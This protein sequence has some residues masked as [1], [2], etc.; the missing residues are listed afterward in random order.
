MSQEIDTL[1]EAVRDA[2]TSS[3][4]SRGVE[5]A[6]TGS[7]HG[8]RDDGAEVV[9][10][11]ATPGGLVSP[12]VQLFPEDEDWDCDCRARAA[13]CEHTAAAVISLRQARR[14]GKALPER[15]RSAGN[16]G[17]RLS[18][19]GDG[20]AI[21]RMIVTERGETRL[22]T[23]LAALASG[24][25]AGPDFVATQGDLAVEHTLGS[26]RRGR[27]P[28]GVLP[29]LV[30]QLGE[31]GDIRLDG[32]PVAASADALRFV[33]VVED[34]DTGF[35][36]RV[37]REELVD[38]TFE[39]CIA[40][41]NKQLRPLGSS[42]LLGRD[43]DLYGDRGRHFGPDEAG[44]LATEVLPELSDRVGIDVRTRRLPRAVREKPRIALEVSRS[45]DAL[46]LFATLVY[47]DPPI[48]RVDA[49]RLVPLG[50]GSVP[51]RDEAAERGALRRLQR[52]LQL[53]PGRR[54]RVEGEQAAQLAERLSAYDG[55]LQGDAHREFFR[56]A[57]LEAHFETAGDDFSLH[58]ETGGEDEVRRA[59]PGRVLSAWA[60]GESLV[61]LVGGGLAPLPRDWLARFGDRLADLFAAREAVGGKEAALPP[62]V[63]PELAELCAELDAPPPPG[64]SRIE[65]VLDATGE[66]PAAALPADLQATLRDYQRRGI[67]WLCALRDA[68]LGALLADDMGL[69]KT[70][71][72]LCALRGRTLVVCP[73]SVLPNWAA[74]AARF[75]PGLSVCVYH[76]AG[77]K[78][79]PGADLTLTTYAL[80][81]L[82]AKHLCA[83]SWDTLVLDEAQ[84]VKNPDSQVA[85]AAYTL[86]ADFRMALTGTPI[87]NRLDELWSQLHFT[88]PGL[89]GGRRDF[90]ER[91]ARPI[92]AG[93]AAAAAR[94]RERIRPFLLRRLKAEVAPELPPRTETTLYAELD[95]EERRLYDALV[96]ATREDVV[97]QLEGGGSVLAA[98]EVLLR[99]R[100][101]CCHRALVPG[102]QAAGSSK[103]AVLMEELDEAV[104]EGHKAL[105]FSQWTSMLDLVEP[106]LASASLP[107]G[108]LDGSTRDRAGVVNHFQAEDGPPVLLLSL[109]AGGTGLN[110]TA[111]DHVFILDPWW[112]PAVEDQAAD[113]AHRI[114]Q[115]R[116]VM[117]H[118]L[119]ARDSVEERV[120]ALQER[121]R[122]LS[123]AALSDGG[124]A[125]GLTREDLL[126]LLD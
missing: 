88:N 116:P 74:E 38:E 99:L 114:G 8:E 57:P 62:A 80:L 89:L 22:T 20:L 117:V 17:Y 51:L 75:R 43:L 37:G 54:I 82:D 36:V 77:R 5:L 72:A 12:T 109:T 83:E 87:E 60:R 78:L 103:L 16:I 98:L 49:G 115:D 26:K 61:P 73:T 101:A 97:R 85:R 32:E 29:R 67:D 93:D 1:F 112:N 6:R 121:K 107:F 10:R 100:Q 15:R 86:R 3:T 126:A 69:G 13:A 39:S 42:G 119:V 40:L 14:Q 104:S 58:F 102:Q 53:L 48:A 111:A 11:V 81:R 9:L 18:R 122:E 90:D 35:R 125:A 94:L 92:A 30:S 110:L 52:E 59:D 123:R 50:S 44:V 7:V 118:R 105:V 31:C 47:G 66:L 21:E 95:Q 25:V 71:E 19:E 91:V 113:R 84:N 34:D 63:L 24:R 124:A 41:C 28:R 2:A 56:T 68:G 96:A 106:H 4:W 79:N 64:L 65:H 23:T 76:G 108:R 27:I 45:G 46:E 120:L 33:A 70:L 55:S